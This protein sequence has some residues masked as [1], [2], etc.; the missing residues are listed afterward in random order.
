MNRTVLSFLLSFIIVGVLAALTAGC[1][2]RPEV[3]KPFGW[4]VTGKPSDSILMRLDRVLYGYGNPDSL[5]A[6]VSMYEEVSLRE[7]PDGAYEHRRL[8]WRGTSLFMRGDFE[9]G[10]SLRRLA[11]DKCDSARFPHD[12]RLYRLV[13]EQSTDFVDNSGRYRRYVSD[14]QSFLDDGD[15]VSAFSRGVMLSQLMSEAGLHNRALDYALLADSLL[16]ESCLP[17]LRT[18][19]MV[20]VASCRFHA[21]DTLGALECLNQLKSD[22]SLE[23]NRVLGAIIDFNKYQMDGDSAAL[24]AAWAK[25]KDDSTLTRMKILLGASMVKERVKVGSDM[26]LNSFLPLLQEADEYSYLPEEDLLIKGA[27]CDIEAESGGFASLKAA[28][29]EYEETVERYLEE[30]K[31][32]EIIAAETASLINQVEMNA[33]EERQR[34]RNMWWCAL[35]VAGGI[36]AICVIYGVVYVNRNRRYR[37]LAQMEIER[38]RRKEMASELMLAEKDKIV[39][40][41]Q[42]RI[43][44]YVVDERQRSRCSLDIASAVYDSN[45]GD[46]AGNTASGDSGEADAK[47]MQ[48]FI[49]RYRNVGK[50]GRRLALYIRNGLDTSE[51]AKAMNIRKESVMQARWRLRSQMNLAPEEDLEAVIHKMD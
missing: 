33:E 12:Y 40:N 4:E 29:V 18:G 17:M 45:A 38:G 26:S 6:L 20:N 15:L 2:R 41:L 21:G 22:V 49:G 3:L 11:M 24:Y 5:D 43:D 30:Q 19:N 48:A 34:N 13:T 37:L 28:V 42:K 16:N 7:D 1:N 46:R 10:D 8:Y 39:R 14:L 32:G 35:L 23:D 27:I 44:R 51:I 50:T 9:R 31:K 25:V 36:A 47:F